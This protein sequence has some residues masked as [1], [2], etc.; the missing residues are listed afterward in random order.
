MRI[1]REGY[2]TLFFTLVFLSALAVLI[3]LI[4]TEQTTWH[5]IAY[6]FF[7]LFFLFI[8]QFFRNPNRKTP[9]DPNTIISAADG[10]VVV[11]EKTFEDEYLHD[12]RIQISVFMSPV[13]VHANRYPVSGVVSYYQYHPGKYLVAWHPKSST[14]NERNTLVIETLTF[15]SVLVRQIAGAVAR[16]IV[17]YGK[18][19]D[20]VIQGSEM[21]FIKFGSRVDI[22]LPTNARINVKI[23]DP[24][25]AGETILAYIE[26]NGSDQNR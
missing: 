12:E 16:R 23:G 15:G 14:E 17:C 25:K 22:F 2:T 11:I 1:H 21:G 9:H 10:K 20:Q 18:P 5:F 4:W 19:E 13:N 8:L 26:E 3:N 7:V 6:G 24:V